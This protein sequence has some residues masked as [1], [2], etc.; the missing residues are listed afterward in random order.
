MWIERPP[1]P[2]D[3]D[4]VVQIEQ[5]VRP[6]LLWL[7]DGDGRIVTDN[8]GRPLAD[9]DFAER[10]Y[11]RVKDYEGKNARDVAEDLTPAAVH[12][13]DTRALRYLAMALRDVA[14]RAIRR[15]E[16]GDKLRAVWLADFELATMV[17]R[18][19]AE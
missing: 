18:V 2:D 5:H 16:R 6:I 11:G 19:R 15:Q 8:R 17:V 9:E 4:H 1:D 12:A 13:D 10:A 3:P 7:R 14:E